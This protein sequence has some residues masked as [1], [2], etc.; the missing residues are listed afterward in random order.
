MT[1]TKYIHD[2]EGMRPLDLSEALKVAFPDGIPAA[3][4]APS[5]TNL[6]IEIESQEVEG[7]VKFRWVDRPDTRINPFVRVT[8]D[9]QS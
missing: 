6:V 4:P 5:K 2:L 7:G 8:K 1:Q 3:K 9:D